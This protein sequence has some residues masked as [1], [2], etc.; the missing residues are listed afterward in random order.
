M[1]IE[2][3]D[4]E[5]LPHHTM[6]IA[7]GMMPMLGK[8]TTKNIQHETDATCSLQLLPFRNKRAQTETER[9]RSSSETLF[10]AVS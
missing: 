7:H 5:L 2:T 6:L 1:F 10:Y 9:G 8:D 3:R 4:P